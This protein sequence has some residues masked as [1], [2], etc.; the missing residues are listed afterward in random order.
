LNLI[1]RFNPATFVCLFQARTWIS[2]VICHGF[3][4]FS[5]FSSDDRGLIVLLIDIGGTDD[6][7]CLNF[8]FKNEIKSTNLMQIQH[9]LKTI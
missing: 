3:Y 4:V 1:H 6:H 2:N 8:L 9:Q 5:E 7:H